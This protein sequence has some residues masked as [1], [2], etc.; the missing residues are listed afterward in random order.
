MGV[1]KAADAAKGQAVLDLAGIDRAAHFFCNADQKARLSSS[2]P[3]ADSTSL[4]AATLIMVM[5]KSR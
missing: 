1:A 2:M 4:R 3:T 5:S